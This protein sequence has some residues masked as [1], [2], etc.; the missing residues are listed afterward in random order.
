MQCDNISISRSFYI[1]PCITSTVLLQSALCKAANRELS[2]RGITWLEV[3]FSRLNH[4]KKVSAGEP[5]CSSHF[6]VLF[7]DR[8]YIL[9]RHLFS[10]DNY[11]NVLSV[12]L[13]W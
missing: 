11:C 5:G 3:Q 6:P 9:F 4:F 1:T 8:S 7:S 12:G 10:S 13:H 2:R